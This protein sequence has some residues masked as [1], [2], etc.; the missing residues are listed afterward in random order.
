MSFIWTAETIRTA[1]EL[2]N[3][4]RSGSEIARAINA[5]SR[6]SV[7]RKISR[8][9]AQGV[10]V[11]A[12]PSPIKAKLVNIEAEMPVVR[13]AAPARGDG[14][15]SLLDA[16]F[17]QCRYPLWETRSDLKLVC[18]KK[19]RNVNCSWCEEHDALVWRP[20]EK[21]IRLR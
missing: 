15:V 9:R 7:T 12:R 21:R 17:R 3:S 19:T 10:S 1:I 2:W 16:G 18:G 6:D 13:T 20:A 8:L 11:E 14:P 5:P 4:G